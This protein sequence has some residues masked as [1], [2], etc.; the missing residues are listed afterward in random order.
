[1]P[2][3]NAVA[4]AVYGASFILTIGAS[5]AGAW[6][7]TMAAV[8]LALFLALELWRT[9]W[10]QRLAGCGLIV[11]GTA[12]CAA[13]GDG[14]ALTMEGL[15]QTLPFLVLFA[16]VLCLQVPAQ[17][18]PSL[19]AIGGVIVRQPPGRRFLAVALGAHLLGALLN[20]AG[21]Q[22]VASVVER[23]ASKSLRERLA[24]AM[25]RGFSAAACW[26]P[27]FVSTSAVL[28]VVHGLSW[29]DIGPGGMAA[30]AALVGLAWV[31]DRL[32]RQPETAPAAEAA[33]RLGL[34]VPFKLA[35]VFLMLIGPVLALVELGGLTIAIALGIVAP[36]FAVGWRAAILGFHVPIADA[37]GSVFG[38]A[39]AR[40]PDL[41][42]E[43][44]L[45][46]GASMLGVGIGAILRQQPPAG[47]ELL[48]TLPTPAVVAGIVMSLTAMGII[49]LHPVVPIIVVGRA[50][51]PEALGLAPQALA[52][53]LMA[54]WGLAT[55][56][57]PF[58]AT[59]MYTARLLHRPVWVVAWRWQAAYGLGA[60]A[61]IGTAIALL[62]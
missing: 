54:G 19:H 42:A 28:S 46:T 47:L 18:S 5:F 56:V 36:L 57:S 26:S 40:L 1:M 52:L 48:A 50:L 6:M 22:F 62:A 27:L 11:A 7:A 44:L 39:R 45:F 23:A 14:L 20:L 60:A 49:G 59:A 9:P 2:S 30:G 13:A 41:R 38:H 12:A 24:L 53:A 3:R 58:S 29:F 16:A 31:H 4:A 55:M 15:R 34:A 8:L 17:T 51:S 61:I 37:A 35:G 43:A 32:R 10:P 33:V 21:M 25:M